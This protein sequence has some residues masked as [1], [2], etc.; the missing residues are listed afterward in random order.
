MGPVLIIYIFGSWSSGGPLRPSFT[1]AIRPQQLVIYEAFSPKLHRATRQP[2]TLGLTAPRVQA[3]KNNMLLFTRASSRRR[4]T[5]EP[6]FRSCSRL[7]F[8]IHFFMRHH[9]LP[10]ISI[11]IPFLKQSGFTQ[12]R[13][14][15]IRFVFYTICIL[16]SHNVYDFC[17]F[18]Y[19]NREGRRKIIMLVL[20]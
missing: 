1:N 17:L 10:L 16:P 20:L 3:P 14:Q 15:A 8:F 2:L 18:V 13:L 5:L 9:L 19:F 6:L 12:N 4:D 7:L 11:R